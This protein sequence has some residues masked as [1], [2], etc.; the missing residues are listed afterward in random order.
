MS[1]G[2]TYPS[3]QPAYVGRYQKYYRAGYRATVDATVTRRK[4]QALQAIGYSYTDIAEGTLMTKGQVYTIVTGK[5]VRNRAPRTRVR[6]G[7]AKKIDQFF[8]EHCNKPK[9]DRDGNKVITWSR[10]RGY[11]PPGAWDD[12]DDLSCTP[13]GTQYLV[14][15]CRVEGCNTPRKPQMK[16][17]GEHRGKKSE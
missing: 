3:W 13:K 5:H 1:V 11:H 10:K 14:P 4:I 17:C 12:I 7:T 6:V 9:R 8:R 16:T 2:Q 15:V